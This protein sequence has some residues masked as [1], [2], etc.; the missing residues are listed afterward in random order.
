M[1]GGKGVVSK[2]TKINYKTI[3][4]CLSVVVIPLIVQIVISESTLSSYAWFSD[5]GREVD[6]FLIGKMYGILILAPIMFLIGAFTLTQNP[7]IYKKRL[8]GNKYLIYFAL[9]YM[10]CIIVSTFF[11]ENIKEAWLGGYAQHESALILIS[12]LVFCVFAYMFLENEDAICS[13]LKI[14]LCGV[15]VI[16]LIGFCQW[17][18]YDFFTTMIGKSLISALSEIQ[19]SQIS[20]SFEEGR[21]YM[22][23]YNPNYVGSYVALVLPVVIASC[24]ILQKMWQRIGL[25][26]I[27]VMLV[28]SLIGSKSTTGMTAIMCS[29]VLFIILSIPRLAKHSK[30]IWIIVASVVCVIGMIGVVNHDSLT[31]AIEKYRFQKDNFVFDKILLHE[32]CVELQIRGDSLYIQSSEQ[33]GEIYLSLYDMDHKPIQDMSAYEGVSVRAVNYADSTKGFAV[34]ADG[35]ILNF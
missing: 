18:R 17:V 8:L 9:I 5:S 23:L 31:Q 2:N 26:A 35:I 30:Q 6:F 10:V 25:S 33:D 12:Y 7:S 4:S 34:E 32:E 1:Q 20:L 27:I 16:S 13:F 3:I 22:T 11:A 21:V 15:A 19:A 29:V 14:A 28:C 24:F